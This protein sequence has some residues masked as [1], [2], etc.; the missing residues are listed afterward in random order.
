[1]GRGREFLKANMSIG[2]QWGQVSAEWQG[3]ALRAN[4]ERGLDNDTVSLVTWKRA[5]GRRGQSVAPTARAMRR[6]IGS[7]GN[8]AGKCKT[9]RRAERSTHTAA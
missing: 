1:M 7:H 3:D 2:Q 6:H 4:E 8:A 9:I 5:G